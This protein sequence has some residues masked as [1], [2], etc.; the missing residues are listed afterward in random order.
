MTVS[1]ALHAEEDEARK[2]LI[3]RIQATAA[4]NWFG[5][6][7]EGLIRTDIHEETLVSSP[8]DKQL[9]T[10]TYQDIVAGLTQKWKTI[11]E[12]ELEHVCLKSLILFGPKGTQMPGLLSATPEL[13]EKLP[14]DTRKLLG[15]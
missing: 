12:K 6:N 8:A 7:C 1:P 10:K 4:A 5:K 9:A 11:S 14:I 2:M 15:F 13:Q 3:A